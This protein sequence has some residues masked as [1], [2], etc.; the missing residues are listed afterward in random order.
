MA[1]PSKEVAPADPLYPTK[2]S[3][4][5]RFGFLP[6]RHTR[7]A[8]AIMS[9]TLLMVFVLIAWCIVVRDAQLLDGP[10]LTDTTGVGSCPFT[11]YRYSGSHVN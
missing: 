5:L 4:G 3:T 9:S 6:S 11:T 1:T 8:V 7:M 2:P 10:G